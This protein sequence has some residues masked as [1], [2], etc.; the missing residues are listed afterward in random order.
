MLFDNRSLRRLIIPLILE[1]ALSVTI[2]MADTVMVASCGEAAVSGISLVDTLNFLMV[3]ILGAMATGGAVI[4]AQYVGKKDFETGRASANQLVV[5][6]TLVSA[7]IAVLALL[8]HSQILHIVYGDTGEEVMQNAMTYFTISAC[9]YI[10][11]GL[12]NAGSALFR[13]MGNSKISLYTSLVMNIINICGNALFIFV[14][15]MG[16]FG[17]GLATLIARI[18]A[19]VFIIWRLTQ[20]QH[21]IHLEKV[22]PFHFRWDMV[23][24][25]LRIGIPNGLE[26]G[27]F[28]IGKI[29]V[30][31]LVSTFGTASIAANAV[32]N[33][34]ANIQTMCAAAIGTSLITVVGQCVGAKEYA[35][36]K[37]YAKKLMF[38]AMLISAVVSLFTCVNVRAILSFY[39]LSEE[40]TEIAVSMILLHGVFSPIIWPWSFAFPNAMRAT[41]DVKYTM[42]VSILSMWLFRVGLSYFLGQTMGLGTFGVYIAMIIDWTIRAACFIPRFFSGKWEKF[43]HI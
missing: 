31:S 24:D 5:T 33:N 2:G 28:Q 37:M 1:H 3:T 6:V 23:K 11:V 40:G 43:Q 19:S 4:T 13:A 29:L 39:N 16:V 7:V 17:A 30:A 42:V 36:A 41:N 34:V 14:F 38:A 25:I 18:C 8:F 27:I 26:N 10:F 22:F 9:S 20:K 32:S 21:P 35:Q 12:Y 15:H